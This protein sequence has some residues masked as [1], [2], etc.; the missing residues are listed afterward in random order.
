MSIWILT[1]LVGV[2]CVLFWTVIIEQYITT[3]LLLIPVVLYMVGALCSLPAIPVLWAAFSLLNKTELSV[4]VARMIMII[5][6]MLI[7]VGI[8]FGTGALV[9]GDLV[10]NALNP[11]YAFAGG[12]ATWW[13]TRNYPGDYRHLRPSTKSVEQ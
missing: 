13:H 9:F 1:P 7:A 5:T 2:I 11:I 4:R 8:F 3:E 6:S 12:A 10:T